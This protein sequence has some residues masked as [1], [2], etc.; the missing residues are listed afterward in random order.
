MSATSQVEVMVYRPEGRHPNADTLEIFKPFGGY[1]VV[2]KIGQFQPGE[3]VAYIPPDNV[4]PEKPEYAFLWGDKEPVQRRRRVKVRAFRGIY[5]EG[6]LVRAPAGAAVGQDVAKE[7][8][9][10]HWEDVPEEPRRDRTNGQKLK[11]TPRCFVPK[12]DI[13]PLKKFTNVLQPDE[14]VVVTEK[15]H[16]ANA[17]FL[18]LLSP[19]SRIPLI[20]RFFG[21]RLWVGSRSEWKT[22]DSIWSRVVKNQRCIEQFCKAMPG[23]ALFGEVYGDVQDLKYG[24]QGGQVKFIAFDIYDTK[25]KAWLCY[26]EFAELCNAYGVPRAPVLGHG[27]ASAFDFKG[28]AEGSSTIAGAD[29]VREGCVVRPVKERRHALVGRVQLKIVGNGYLER[30]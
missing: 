8:G 17:R 25:A 3:L 24:C 23:Y 5:S 20:G 2:A 21:G 19:L 16:G 13:E 29:H 7:L 15:V 18:Y 12:Y 4:V 11:A 27:P 28:L 1:T 10:E 26:D 14:E 22:G 9:I 30:A 6:L